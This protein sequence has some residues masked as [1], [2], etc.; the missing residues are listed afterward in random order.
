MPRTRIRVVSPR[1]N[2]MLRRGSK[3]T[4]PRSSHF[5][6]TRQRARSRWRPARP[7]GNAYDRAGDARDSSATRTTALATRTTAESAQLELVRDDLQPLALLLQVRQA[8]R[9]LL[10]P[11]LGEREHV[12]R[13]ARA[14]RDRRRLLRAAAAV[15]QHRQAQEQPELQRRAAQGLGQRLDRFQLQL[16]PVALDQRRQ[17]LLVLAREARHVRVGDDVG[18]VLLV[19]LVRD[20]E[21]DLVQARGP[22]EEARRAL[23][24]ELPLLAALAQEVERGALHAARLD[25]VG[26]VALGH[27]PNGLL[28]QVLVADAAE[29]GPVDG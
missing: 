16:A 29:Q 15:E 2:R 11:A 12:A 26:G 1:T 28:A 3:L 7:L 13:L 20:R 14:Q 21:A 5:G 23:A 22:G 18:A 8:Q 17:Q 27:A 4:P 19:G 10:H 9:V 24:L 25:P 6:T